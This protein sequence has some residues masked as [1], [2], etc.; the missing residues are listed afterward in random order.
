MVF[1][2]KECHIRNKRKKISKSENQQ[3]YLQL[4]LFFNEIF[5]IQ[6][7]LSNKIHKSIKNEKFITNYSLNQLIEMWWIYSGQL[8]EQRERSTIVEE[9]RIGFGFI[10]FACPVRLNFLFL[11]FLVYYQL[12]LDKKLVH[13]NIIFNNCAEQ[14]KARLYITIGIFTP[15]YENNHRENSQNDEGRSTEHTQACMHTRTHA[16]THTHKHAYTHSY[17]YNIN[18]YVYIYIYIYIYI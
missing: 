9:V 5:R 8:S 11:S 10:P 17:I 6:C 3:N 7:S 4:K 16:Y 1:Q 14:I 13:Y 12:I 15:S 2:N 18:K